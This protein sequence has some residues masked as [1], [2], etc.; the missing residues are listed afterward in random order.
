M[1]FDRIAFYVAI[2][3]LAVVSAKAE[4]AG[5]KT[6]LEKCFV[7]ITNR[8]DRHLVGELSSRWGRGYVT[9]MRSLYMMSE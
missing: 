6:V 8:P 5:K 7:I 4:V 3:E 2:L 9:Y 1:S